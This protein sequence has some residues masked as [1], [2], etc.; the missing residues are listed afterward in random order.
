MQVDMGTINLDTM[1]QWYIIHF[2]LF[3]KLQL[4]K[5]SDFNTIQWYLATL[6]TSYKCPDNQGVPIFQVMYIMQVSLFSSV[7]INRFHYNPTMFFLYFRTS[8]II[9]A[10]KKNLEIQNHQIK[11]HTKLKPCTP[12]HPWH[13]YQYHWF[14]RFEIS[15]ISAV[16]CPN[17]LH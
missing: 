6:G 1:T 3:L 10:N 7:L 15:C 12:Q 2:S 5:F 8:Q 16:H 14:W 4:A 17:M 9:S 13:T 11:F